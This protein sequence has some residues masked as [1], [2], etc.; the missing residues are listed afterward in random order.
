MKISTLL[1]GVIVAASFSNV[2]LAHEYQLGDLR[3]DHPYARATAPG[4]PAGGAYLEISNQGKSGDKLIAVASPAARSTEI[5]TMSMEGDVMKM[6]EVGVIDIKPSEKIT[7]RPGNGYHIMMIGLKQ[8]LK[9]GDKIPL[10]LTFEKAG[11]LEVSVQV[12]EMKAGTHT[13]DMSKH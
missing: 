2:A 12:E 3:I 10:T 1:F 8:Q 5:H 13:M 4:Q 6:R 11:K 9:A 7:M